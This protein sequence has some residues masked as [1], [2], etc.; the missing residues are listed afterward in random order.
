MCSVTELQPPPMFM[1][2]PSPPVRHCEGIN[3]HLLF[4]SPFHIA[5]MHLDKSSDQGYN[6]P[7]QMTFRCLLCDLF[8][9]Q[10]F[11]LVPFSVPFSLQIVD[12][13][14]DSIC[15]NC[16]SAI[17]VAVRLK[18][19][20]AL[21]LW[22]TN[23]INNNNLPDAPVQGIDHNPVNKATHPHSMTLF[24]VETFHCMRCWLAK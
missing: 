20:T 17:S 18:C 23:L 12:L 3:S 5:K 11:R 1:Y 22:F 13:W 15:V 16:P 24:W 7:S 4:A 21:P 2:R 19:S 14:Q 10:P 9:R 6:I 8:V